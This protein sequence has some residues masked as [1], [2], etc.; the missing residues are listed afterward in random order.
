MTEKILKEIFYGKG[1]SAFT[2]INNV[3]KEAKKKYKN[4][5]LKEVRDF[6]VKQEAYTLHFPRRK[7]F[8]RNPV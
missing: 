5:T 6:M 2:T 3:Y 4:I 1:P 7:V 8:K